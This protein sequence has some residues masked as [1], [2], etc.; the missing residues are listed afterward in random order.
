MGGC[1][2]GTHKNL[3]KLLVG[4]ILGGHIFILHPFWNSV[5]HLRQELWKHNVVDDFIPTTKIIISR[6]S[7]LS[8]VSSS[9]FLNDDL[10]STMFQLLTI[11]SALSAERANWTRRMPLFGG[12]PFL[13]FISFFLPY[14]L[15]GLISTHTNSFFLLSPQ[16]FPSGSRAIDT[17]RFFLSPGPTRSQLI[18]RHAPVFP[19]KAL[20]AGGKGA[21]FCCCPVHLERAN[22]TRRMLLFGG[23]PYL[24][25]ISFFALLSGRV[26]FNTY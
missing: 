3:S 21:I 25:F 20:L 7:P 10:V 13:A 17:S 12:L 6:H 9:P 16:V 5:H 4:G 15:V 1:T 11:F 18:G 14:F 22:W 8:H 26:N 19:S 24:A 2:F 23:L